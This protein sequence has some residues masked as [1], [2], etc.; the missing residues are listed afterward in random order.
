MTDF[1]LGVAIGFVF[2]TVFWGM[3]DILYETLREVKHLANRK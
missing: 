2:A 1:L 3:V